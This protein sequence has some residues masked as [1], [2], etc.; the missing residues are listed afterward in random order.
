M[1]EHPRRTEGGAIMHAPN[2]PAK[3]R[4]AKSRVYELASFDV[5]TRSTIDLKRYG[6]YRYAADKST[7][8]R[9][10]AWA[11]DDGPVQLWVTGQPPPEELVNHIRAGGKIL[12]HNAAFDRLIVEKILGPRHGW[13]VPAI[14]QWRCSMAAALALALPASLEDGG[15]AMNLANL[16]DA[17]GKRVMQ[18][19]AKPRKAR[20]DESEAEVHWH[21]DEAKTEQLHTYC[22]G[23]VATMREFYNSICPLSDDE[24]TVWTMDQRINDRGF[25]VDEKLLLAMRKIITAAG[26]DVNTQ[27][28][29]LTGG[30]VETVDKVARL[31]TWLQEVCGI[32]INSLSK[33]TI[34][35][36]IADKKTP[37]IA[38]E[39]LELRLAGAQAAV[40]KVEAF[41][42]RRSTDG[43]VHGAFV[44]HAA[45]PGRWSSKGAQVHNLKRMME[46]DP[47][48]IEAT[49][50]DL[51]TGDYKLLKTKYARPLQVVGNNIRTCICAAEGNVLIGGDYSGIEAR[52]TAWVAGEKRKLQVFRDFDA[53]LGPDPYI[54]AATNIYGLSVDRIDKPEAERRQGSRTRFRIPGWCRRLQEICSAGA[55][56]DEEIDVFKNKWRRAHP[57]IVEFWDELKDAAHKI[58]KHAVLIKRG[59]DRTI[60]PIQMRGDIWIEYSA[61]FMF[62]T[63]PSGRRIAYP[64][65]DRIHR[66]RDFHYVEKPGI[67]SAH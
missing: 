29:K 56:T 37:E 34:P 22:M 59:L 13:P 50:A 44:Y 40:K 5:E 42:D 20:K 16:K 19:M 21:D 65:I 3:K 28:S 1:P 52:I 10:A 27:M 47:A 60:E 14:A 15:K 64:D 54:I 43:R 46:E 38:K 23:D 45:G 41:L 51:M 8:A 55:F 26:I 36:L 49:V 61:G 35:P 32:E 12:S 62:V 9:C 39:V 48:A 31:K 2:K 63:L 25:H 6:A 67:S 58:A 24:Q 4:K 30:A 53:G 17:I 66:P 11:L 33:T 57:N 7:E 18:Q